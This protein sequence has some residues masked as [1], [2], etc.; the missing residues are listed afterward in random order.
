V[1]EDCVQAKRGRRE[2]TIF[3]SLSMVAHFAGALLAAVTF[4]G[5]GI[6]GLSTRNCEA[7]C[8]A[9]EALDQDLCVDEC[10]NGTIQDQ[11]ESLRLYIQFVMGL[12][13]PF[14]ELLTAFNAYSFPIKGVR[15]RRLYHLVSRS[16]GEDSSITGA[17][18]SDV[19]AH[20]GR[21]RI[22]LWLDESNWLDEASWAA[23]LAHTNALMVD[24]P[25]KKSVSVLFDTS[26][27]VVASTV[28]SFSEE[29]SCTDSGAGDPGF[30]TV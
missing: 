11:P 12:W 10:F 18:D 3:G 17:K 13:A 7:F 4:F 19:P 23:R 26:Q 8:R 16:R 27:P 30:S 25:G 1:D 2:A 9:S 14:C 28:S 15:L 24:R 21:S 20:Q 5:L 22:V 6:A 29:L